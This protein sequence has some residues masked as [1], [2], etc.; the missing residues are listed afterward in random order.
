MPRA[1]PLIGLLCGLTMTGCGQPE[2]TAGAR[3]QCAIGADA[4]WAENCLVERQGGLLTLRHADG[5]FRRFRIVSDGRGVLSADGAEDASI[6]IIG[7]N[8]IELIVGDDHYRLPALL[9]QGAR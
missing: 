2:E 9:S 3:I 5:G 7:R 8:R 1:A 6:R 4:V